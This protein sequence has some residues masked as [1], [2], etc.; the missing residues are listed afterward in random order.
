MDAKHRKP[1]EAALG[2]TAVNAMM[3][4][5]APPDEFRD[6]AE[7]VTNIETVDGHAWEIT[8]KYGGFYGP[9]KLTENRH[10]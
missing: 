6:D 10:D 8:I 2:R 7:M 1:L 3:D 9:R 5:I 4:I